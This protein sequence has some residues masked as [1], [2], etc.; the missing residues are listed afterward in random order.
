V[1]SDGMAMIVYPDDQQTSNP[2]TYFTKQTGGSGVH[3]N[4]VATGSVLEA[5]ADIPRHFSLEENYP[6]PFNPS[7]TIRYSLPTDSYVKL[8]IYNMLGQEISTLVNQ[9]KGAGVYTVSW[10]ASNVSSGVYFY[11]L[12]T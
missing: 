2:L 8:S 9:R 11:R 10:D 4:A 7:T 5:A 1:Y 6:N 12:A 3:A